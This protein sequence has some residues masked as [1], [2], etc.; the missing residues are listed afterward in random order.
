M[1]AWTGASCVY[2]CASCPIDAASEKGAIDAAELKRRLM[3]LSQREGRLVVLVGGEPMLRPDLLRLFAT[4][5]NADCR[6]GLVTTGRALNY[7]HVREKVRRAGLDYLRIQ[8]FGA[9]HTHD[10]TTRVPG[11]Y[12]QAIAGV[13]AWLDEA[14]DCD[15]DVALYTRQRSADSLAAEVE[16]IDRDIGAREVQILVAGESLAGADVGAAMTST[17]GWNDDS[18]HSLLLWEGLAETASPAAR[19]T[20]PA[21]GGRFVGVRPQASCLGTVDRLA[22][23]G[24]LVVRSNSFNFIRADAS[25][26]YAPQAAEC[27]A[28]TAASADDRDR[29]LWLVE[30]DR[31]ALYATDTGDFSAD[32]IARV[33]DRWSHLF[34]DRAEAGVLDDFTEG[35]RRVRPDPVCDG[36]A[37]RADCAHRFTM[38]DGPPFAAEEAWIADYV[39]HLR[40]RVL[41]VGCGEQLYRDEIVPLVRSGIVAYTGI[42]PDQPSLDEWRTLLPEGRFFQGGVEDF[43]GLPASYDRVLCLRSLNHVYDL[44]EAV[45]RM[46]SLMKPRG[47]LLIVETTPFAML[48]EA[49]QVAHADRAPRAGHQHFRNVTSEDVLPYARRRGLEVLHHHPV[50]LETTNEW[51]LLLERQG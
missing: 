8:L 29:Q 30:D 47:Q 28:H 6:T 34:V 27:S 4:I 44:D 38:V 16:R 19:A 7:P 32:E 22:V 5:H 40:G 37:H 3:M 21:I 33:K 43:V 48:R 2:G 11:G 50:G 31:L 1:L 23:P 14:D 41:D 15:V 24:E 42:D 45:A 17:A 49:E 12:E 20:I 51:I 39:K 36:C 18:S 25:T 35:M 46:A 9:G 13:R 10:A 26:A